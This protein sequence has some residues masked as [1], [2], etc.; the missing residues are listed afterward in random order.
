MQFYSSIAPFYDL[1]FP[2]DEQQIAFLKFAADPQAGTYIT[3]RSGKRPVSRH[4]MLD[5]GCGTGT[6]LSAFSDRFK[7]L[8]GV[9]ADSELLKLAA[10]KV[11][12]G[13][14]KKFELLLEDMS[15]LESL[16]PEEEF[17]MICC[18]GNTLVHATNP[19]KL[20]HMLKTVRSMLETDGVFII[21]IINYDRVL[22]S[23]MR[24]LPTIE[25]GETTFERY[26]SALKD[27]GLIDFTATLS[28][29]DKEVEITNTVP[30]IP[31][32]KKSLQGMLADAGFVSVD[33]YGDYSGEPWVP[34][35]YLT[36]AVCG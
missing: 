21:Q 34:E 28:V 7:N 23:G 9:D 15:S 5:I 29:P 1:I 19:G 3:V 12:P 25:S 24:G 4:R 20:Q 32:R 11:Y 6:V 36:I 13:E 35:S 22:D 33:F 27:D 17:S 10:E 26:Y 30:I 2:Y 14:E 31:L 16:F 8:V 18:L